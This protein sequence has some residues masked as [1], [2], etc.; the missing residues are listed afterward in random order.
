MTKEAFYACPEW[1]RRKLKQVNL[2]Y[3]ILCLLSF[4]LLQEK[5]LF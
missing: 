5:S 3:D 1:R 4:A 2:G